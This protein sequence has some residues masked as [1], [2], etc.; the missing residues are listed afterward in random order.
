MTAGREGALFAQAL[1]VIMCWTIALGRLGTCLP[2]KNH[3]VPEPN[4]KSPIAAGEY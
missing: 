2:K 4:Y 1:K 3:S